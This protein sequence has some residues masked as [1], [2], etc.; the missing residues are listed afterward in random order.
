ML[1]YTKYLIQESDQ[2]D[3]TNY[4]HLVGELICINKALTMVPNAFQA[5]III[6]Y[7]KNHSLKLEWIKANP[8]FVQL[9]TSGALPISNIEAL[10][11]ASAYLD[12]TFEAAV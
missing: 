5:E 6:S 8:E 2:F 10:F 4:P 3:S 1:T 12:F 7:T 11:E 9:V